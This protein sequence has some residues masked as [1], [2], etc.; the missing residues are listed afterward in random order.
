[1]ALPLAHCTTSSQNILKIYK[2]LPNIP[3]LLAMEKALNGPKHVM[4]NFP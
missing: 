3:N 4:S 2:N 1:M